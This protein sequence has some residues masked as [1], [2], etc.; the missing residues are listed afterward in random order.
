[1]SVLGGETSKR[2]ASASTDP[3]ACG[4]QAVDTRL[5]RKVEQ[6]SQRRLRTR[7]LYSYHVHPAIGNQSPDSSYGVLMTKDVLPGSRSKSY[8]DQYALVA[9]H[10]NRTGLSCKVPRALEATVVML[11]TPC[12]ERRAFVQHYSFH[13]YALSGKS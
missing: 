1:M 4:R 12:P 2:Y 3:I 7:C 5:P 11:L 10:A 9:D 6:G 13:V 8:E